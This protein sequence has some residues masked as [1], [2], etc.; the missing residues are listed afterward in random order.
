[1]SCELLHIPKHYNIES[2]KFTD[3]DK[4]GILKTHKQRTQTNQIL[5]LDRRMGFKFPGWYPFPILCSTKLV[6]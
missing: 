1:M 3:N 5:K 2:L 6:K 4:D